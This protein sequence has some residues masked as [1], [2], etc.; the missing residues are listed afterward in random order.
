MI[1]HRR[2][3]RFKG[4]ALIGALGALLPATASASVIFTNFGA[5]LAYDT[6]QGNP[7]G[8]DFVGDD[9]AQGNSFILSSNAV[10]RSAMV[11]LSCVVGCPAAM[12]FTVDLT[13]D[14]SD[15][16]GTVVESFLFPSA[17]LNAL[18]NNNAPIALTSVL[19]PTLLSGMQYWITVSSSVTYAIVWNNNSTGDTNDQ[20]VSSD[21]GATWFAP[22]GATPGALEVDGTVVPEPS[23]GLLAVTGLIVAWWRKRLASTRSSRASG[24][25]R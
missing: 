23:A 19:H 6:S 20:A 11:A 14:S 4:V 8:N 2:I 3:K 13:A 21:G 24:L 5:S 7:V 15:S 10:F 17:T 1:D 9:A 22:T 12:N 25:S 16:P 18:G